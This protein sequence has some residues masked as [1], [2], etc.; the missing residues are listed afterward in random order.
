MTRRQP[1]WPSIELEK[2]AAGSE[3]FW[4]ALSMSRVTKPRAIPAKGEKPEHPV[5]LKPLS[6]L[7][8][9]MRNP[10]Y[11]PWARK[12]KNEAEIVDHIANDVGLEDVLSSMAVNGYF[13]SEPVIGVRRSGSGPIEV[14]EGNRRLAASIILSDD[15]RAKNQLERRK[16]YG[17]IRT[18]H[19]NQAIE[20]VPVMLFEG[21]GAERELLPHLGV[22]HIVGAQPWSAFSKAAWVAQV[23]DSGEMSLDDVIQMIGDDQRTSERIL[24]AFYMVE[25]L[26]AADRF[27]PA[28]SLRRGRSQAT[29]PFS[30]VYNAIDRPQIRE[31]V[32]MPEGARALKPKPLFGK[33]DNAESLMQFLCGSRSLGIEPAIR[34]SREITSLAKAL[35]DPVSANALKAGKSLAVVERESLPASERISAGLGAA[36]GALEDAV[37]AASG[38]RLRPREADKL[39]PRGRQ[40]RALATNVVELVSKAASA[41]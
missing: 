24:S 17:A 25:Q 9:D 6:E 3:N 33:L 4:H 37:A 10:R 35:S 5:T 15:P 36:Q 41:E 38:G 18:A 11:G 12:F 7:R 16:Q 20:S 14:K 39:L 22:K 26:I 1:R 30:L 13:P 32:G 40:V 28:D 19:G 34:E 8:F 31:W 23:V 27:D 29:F 2:I 21:R